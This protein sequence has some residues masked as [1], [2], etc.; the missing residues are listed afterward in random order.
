MSKKRNQKVRDN[1]G[2]MSVNYQII[3]VK[4]I[5]VLT[6]T[7]FVSLTSFIG[8]G[9]IE[10]KAH[11]TKSNLTGGFR[12]RVYEFTK[13][14]SWFCDQTISTVFPRINYFLSF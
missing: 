9:M 3:A 11:R 12:C 6:A 13:I 4:S 10:R 2:M 8:R 5:F 14:A 1:N 7:I